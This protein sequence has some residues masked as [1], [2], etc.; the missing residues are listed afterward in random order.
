MTNMQYTTFNQQTTSYNLTCLKL[1][2][3]LGLGILVLFGFWATVCKMVCPMPSDSC[4]SV[5]SVTL[6]YCDQM[7]GQSKMKL[8]MQVGLGLGHIVLDGDQAPSPMGHSLPQ[9]LAPI[10]CGRMAQ[11]IKMPLGRKVGLDPSDIVL[12]GDPAPQKRG[13]SPPNSWPMSIVAKRLH[14][15]RCYLV[16]K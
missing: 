10:C 5:L 2:H 8:G 9:F 7:V 1:L 12:D 3:E 4:L 15:S 14:G 16:W 13:Q 6:V 11:W